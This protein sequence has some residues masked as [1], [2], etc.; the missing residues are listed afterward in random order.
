M[1]TP[2]PFVRTMR[3]MNLRAMFR[4]WCR[5]CGGGLLVGIWPALVPA[6]QLP[7]PVV[8]A[9]QRLN[10]P[11]TAMTALVL[12]VNGGAP[13]LSID[14]ARPMNPASTI[15]LVTT[16]AA[17]DLLGADYLWHTRFYADGPVQ[18]GVLMGNLYVRGG[19]DPKFV[20]ERILSAYG[21]LQAQGVQTVMGDWVLD[22]SA[23][24]LRTR[25]EAAFDG[26]ALKPY[27]A[28]PDALLVNFK[29]V[30]LKFQPDRR[31]GVARV[32]VEPPMAELTVPKKVAIRRGACG[33]WRQAL[34][35]RLDDPLRFY[36]SG[37]FPSGCGAAE[38][39]LAYAQPERYAQ[40]ALLGLWN[41]L[42]GRLEGQM[43]E[44]AV[45]ANARLLLS[46][47]SLPLRDI[48]ADVNRFSNNVMAQQVFLTIGDPQWQGA[49]FQRARSRVAQWWRQRVSASLAPPL[50]DNGAGLSRITRISA[51]QM[52]ALLQYAASMP[53]AQAFLASLPV[54]G[55][56]GTV[57]QMGRKG[58]HPNAQ[59][60]AMLKT[61]TLNDVSAI[62]GYVNDTQGR[63][64]IVVGLINAPEGKNARSALYA[65]VEW[66]ASR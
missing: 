65:L 50:I 22:R 20:L 34:G 2:L 59:G 10:M 49:D 15:K 38:W 57:A 1:P 32:E 43:R 55:V 6:N 44:G 29:S 66:A 12:P 60:N 28:Q 11:T 56:N 13:L 58:Q 54:A 41:S 64:L 3:G 9:L 4:R 35:A 21:Q 17:L 39:P 8:E 48:I 27:N 19:G 47:P 37:R 63:R 25:D 51:E 5:R 62:A 26:E 45:A 42:G 31:A 40:R 33:D 61:G 16:A 14:A 36:F 23:F 53:E 18:N 24:A 46:S 52:A 30:I 7:A